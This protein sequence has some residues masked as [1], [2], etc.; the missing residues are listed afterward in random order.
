MQIKQISWILI[1]YIAL[2]EGISLYMQEFTR[3]FDLI[4][5]GLMIGFF[6]MLLTIL[7]YNNSPYKIKINNKKINKINPIV[8][9][10]FN[11]L[12]IAFSFVIQVGIV[13]LE[14]YGLIGF[15][16]LGLISIG[17]A[18]VLSILIYNTANLKIQFDNQT[19]KKIPYSLALVAGFFEF[20]IIPL[21]FIFYAANTHLFL[22]GFV[23][24]LVGSIIPLAI[25]NLILEKKSISL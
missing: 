2:I 1:L 18:A 7:I 8:P 5:N 9:S 20:F 12:F 21:M 4:I 15:A 11:A 17:L 3:S 6:G 22:N 10:I 25:L 23:S 16:L 14:N 24:G 13:R 19:I